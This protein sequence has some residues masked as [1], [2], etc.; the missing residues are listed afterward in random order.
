MESC[1][2]LGE[3]KPNRGLLRYLCEMPS[4]SELFT[5][6]GDALKSLSMP[7]KGTQAGKKGL[8]RWDQGFLPVHADCGHRNLRFSARSGSLPR[9]HVELFYLNI[10]F[11]FQRNA[12]IFLAFMLQYQEL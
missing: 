7:G 5:C 3:E 4:S 2:P 8:S 11:K 10:R 1:E 6:G 12:G 9:K